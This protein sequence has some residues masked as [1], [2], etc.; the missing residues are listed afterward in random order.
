MMY[1]VLYLA[2][3]KYPGMKGGFIHVPYIPNQVVAKPNMPF[4]SLQDISKCL[5]LCI[6]ALVNNT[7]DIKTVGGTIC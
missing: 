1:N 2:D 7:E 5:E 6:E 3:K 4:M